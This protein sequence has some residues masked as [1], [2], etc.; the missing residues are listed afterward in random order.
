MG[1]QAAW[2]PALYAANAGFVPALGN[3]VLAMLD[4]K[5]GERVLDLGCGDGVLTLR[6]AAT[7]AITEGI[8]GDA[9]MAAAA[10][11]R[12]LKVRHLDARA[13]ADEGLFD[14]V[15]SN[16]T[17]HWIRPPETVIDNVVRALKPGG[18]FVGEFGGQGNIAAIRTALAATLATYRLAESSDANFYPQADEYAAMLTAAGLVVETAEIVPRPTP[19]ATGMAAWLETFRGGFLDAAGVSDEDRPAVI[20]ETVERLIPVLRDQPGRWTADYVR[21]R[22]IARLPE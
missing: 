8:D 19:L 1:D 22:F 13:L 2:N 17:L 21:L 16:A 4:P 15:F 5:P 3:V 14:A 6:I 12:G 7:G 20:A 10:R 18:R 11:A 9:A